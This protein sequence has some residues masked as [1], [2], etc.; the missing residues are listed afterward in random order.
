M[1]RHALRIAG[2]IAVP[3][4]VGEAL[5]WPLAFLSS[6]LALQL[7]ASRQPPPTR[8]RLAAV[9]S[10]AIAFFWLSIDRCGA[11]VSGFVHV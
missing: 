3:F 6:V 1:I 9:A 7:L 11:F 8:C 5:D 2:G 4:I 10:I